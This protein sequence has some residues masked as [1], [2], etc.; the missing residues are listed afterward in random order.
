MFKMLKLSEI[1]LTVPSV[2]PSKIP[3]QISQ[4][5]SREK[6]PHVSLVIFQGFLEKKKQPF[7]ISFKIF[8]VF[9]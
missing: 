9:L 8:Y 4:E 3:P 6:L 2:L 7:G 1:H 5:I